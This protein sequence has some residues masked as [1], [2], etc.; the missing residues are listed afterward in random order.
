VDPAGLYIKTWKMG[1]HH[2]VVKTKGKHW[3]AAK[4]WKNKWEMFAQADYGLYKEDG[5][6]GNFDMP[7][8]VFSHDAG[9]LESGPH[10]A[11]SDRCVNLVNQRGGFIFATPAEVH[12]ALEIIGGHGQHR[13]ECHEVPEATDW[14]ASGGSRRLAGRLRGG[15]LEDAALAGELLPPAAVAQGS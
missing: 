15:E 10:Q 2:F 1:D 12:E 11:F 3:E 6:F 14:C 4:Y 5:H 7:A 13:L 9:G 8:L